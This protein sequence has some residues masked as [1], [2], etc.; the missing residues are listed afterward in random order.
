[1]PQEIKSLLLKASM[2]LE[3]TAKDMQPWDSQSKIIK[4][5]GIERDGGITNLYSF[6]EQNAAY[7]E[8]FFTRNGNR[9]RLLRDDINNRMVVYTNDREIGQVP[10]WASDDRRVLS[11]DANDVIATIDGTIL[12]LRIS[13]SLA[14]IEE[15]NTTDQSIIQMRSF[16]IPS[17][18]SDG[19]LVR[20]KQPTWSNVTSIVGVFANGNVLNHEVIKDS[21]VVYTIASQIGFVNSSH[22][23]AYYENGW[24][25]SANDEADARTFLLKSDGTQQGTYTEATYLVANYNES[26]GAIL[27]RGY[28]DVVKLGTPGTYGNLFTPPAA[29]LGSW[30]ITAQTGLA[31]SPSVVKMTM[32]GYA[33]TYGT[34]TK[35][36]FY[37]NNKT[38][39]TWTIGHLT[40]PE[41]YGYL[42]SGA[43]IAFKVHTV[44]G[45]ASYISAS[46]DPDG[47]GTPITEIGELNAY[48]YPQIIKCSAGNYRVI[49]RR[50]NGSFA[51][52]LL[53]K[54]PA[55]PR[56][57]EIAPGVVKINTISALC[58]ADSNDNDLQYSGNAYNGFVVVGFDAVAPLTQK[59]YVARYRGDW[60]GSI[61][62]NYK[63]TG[64]VTVGSVNLVVVPEGVS[65]S[66]NNETIDVYAGDP[67][68]PAYYR[69]IRDGLAQSIKGWLQGTIYVDNQV[70]PPPAGAIMSEQTIA[71]IGSTAIRELNYDGYQLLN[72]T[73]GHYQSFRLYGQLYL[74]D[75]DWIHS[76]Q[77]NGN[78]LVQI[79]HVA[80]A[81][82][83]VFLC[84]SPQAVYF[85]SSY[86]N[87][88]YIFDGGQAVSKYMRLNRAGD[89]LS[90]AYNVRE[91]TLALF[92]D[93]FVLWVRD[94]ILSQSLLPFVYPYTAFSTDDGVWISKGSY[95]IKF[96]YR[97][98]TISG[99][100]IIQLDLDGGI[101]GT[102]YSDTYSGGTWGTS[103]PDIYA[104][105]VWGGVD[106]GSIVPLVWQSK[107]N[108]YSDRIKQS[109][110]RF[111]FRV[112]KEDLEQSIISVEYQSYRE[113]GQTIESCDIIIGDSVNPYDA[114]GYAV[115]EFVP[116]NKNAIASS[117]KL[118]CN[119]KII[120][121][122]GYATITTAGDSVAK[123]RG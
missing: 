116:A 89:I 110:D 114:D 21:G 103:Y 44:L 64:A 85:K 29:P 28:R 112:L 46:F 53:T 59:A 12:V 4:N 79:Q 58:V 37:D 97:G 117:I 17:N 84:E 43:E 20:T 99:G 76:T 65:Y 50:G 8:T 122:N 119:D 9:V 36:L 56:M 52:I 54:H 106:A 49:Y 51:T 7:E 100:T 107:F 61:D 60:G 10:Q 96:E 91:N 120:L 68:S 102:S 25:V 70:I 38:Q 71:L 55:N 11:V 111:F 104:G 42:N 57:Q 73:V 98:I 45:E 69:S 87:S 109:L 108:G 26:T 74:F 41:I 15:V 88:I 62:T 6:F 23:F 80:N 32:G 115:I 75:G 95:S 66:P 93:D 81:L 14:T 63:S 121:L 40:P 5:T 47:I 3:T 2:D 24:I 30:T 13:Q 34:S 113:D 94:G 86:D 83:L 27:F 18:V 16:T 19:F 90:G 39:R 67:P 101:W 82:G 72:E 1:M 48:Y 78:M 33:L 118:T 31:S 35:T 92:G 105:E 22:V 123:N 77:L